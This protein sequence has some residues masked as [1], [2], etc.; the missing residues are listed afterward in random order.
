M[1]RGSL[2][3]LLKS[4]KAIFDREGKT[5]ITLDSNIKYPVELD[6]IVEYRSSPMGTVTLVT[7]KSIGYIPVDNSEEEIEQL[8]KE[9]EMRRDT[10]LGQ[11]L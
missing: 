1:S 5:Y 11:L 10:K 8:I 6:D 7:L 9:A 3:S 2:K 4:K